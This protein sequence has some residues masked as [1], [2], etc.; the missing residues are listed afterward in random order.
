MQPPVLLSSAGPFDL[1]NVPFSR[2]GSF[3]CILED[4]RERE[5]YLS[6]SRSPQMWMQRK[7]LLLLRLLPKRQTLPVSYEA[8]PGRMVVSSGDA[9]AAF[10]MDGAGNL[11]LRVAGGAF[12]FQGE[13]GRVVCD[14]SACVEIRFSILGTLRFMALSGELHLS[15][16]LAGSPFDI[17]CLPAKGEESAEFAVM[18]N[19]APGVQ[20]PEDAFEAVVRTAEKDF[21][22]FAARYFPDPRQADLFDLTAVWTVWSH[23]LG[24]MGNLKHEVVYMTR[25]QWLRAFGWQQ[26]FHSMAVPRDAETAFDLIATIFDY[27][28][29]AGQLPD[30]IGDIGSAYLVTKPALQGLALALWLKRY[31]LSDISAEKRCALYQGFARFA[32]WWLVNRD[33][34]RSGVPQY[35]HG[36]ESPGEFCSCFRK[37]VP[38]YSPDLIAFLVLLTEGCAKLAASLGLSVEEGYWTRR[39]ADLLQRLTRDFWNGERFEFR[40]AATGETVE[41]GAF[42]HLLP[43]MLG[44]RLPSAVLTRLAAQLA[45]ENAYLMPDG[46][47]IE[48]M[49][50]VA[51]LPATPGPTGAPAYVGTLMCIGLMDAGF[52]ALAKKVAGRVVAML[53][54]SGFVFMHG[55]EDDRVAEN[56]PV[57]KWTSWSASCYLL[58]CDILRAPEDGAAA[59]A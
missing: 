46:I 55:P 54:R 25:T 3:L 48:H 59:G 30:S 18:L 31:R 15:G 16:G 7:N 27:Q 1:R 26:S 42:M 34:N 44:H 58:L 6:I 9:G 10:C 20:P 8:E 32:T 21:W 52:T 47:A 28:D 17:I 53:R 14:S 4:D 37:G 36:D 13:D 57:P 23:T 19:P 51:S 5:L 43:V 39:S 38:L 12:S 33:R 45:D 11:R 41:S 29:P 22:N 35:Y 2:R 50:E 56:R 24:P 40:L 49:Q